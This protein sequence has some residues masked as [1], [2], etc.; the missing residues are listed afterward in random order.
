MNEVFRTTYPETYHYI[1]ALSPYSEDCASENLAYATYRL[2]GDCDENCIYIVEDSDIDLGL[3]VSV[4]RN[5]KRYL[6]IIADVLTWH[7]K[8]MLEPPPLPDDEPEEEFIPDFGEKPHA[9]G[10]ICCYVPCL[11]AD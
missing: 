4:E 1:A 7:T 2:D 9:G 5:L 10:C 8:K 6:E 11:A 3:I